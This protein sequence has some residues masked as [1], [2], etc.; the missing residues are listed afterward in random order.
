[1][2]RHFLHTGAAGGWQRGRGIN[3]YANVTPSL[4]LD[5]MRMQ[6]F[7]LAPTAFIEG[8]GTGMPTVDGATSSTGCRACAPSASA[9]P[10]AQRAS[11]GLLLRCDNDLAAFAQPLTVTRDEIGRMTTLLDRGCRVQAGSDLRGEDGVQG[12]HR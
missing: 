3:E 2:P 9:M 8:D 4:F 10:T 1:M 7:A 5:F 6:A 12:R 11:S